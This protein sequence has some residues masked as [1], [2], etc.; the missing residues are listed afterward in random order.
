MFFKFSAYEK[1][2]MDYI[3]DKI[4]VSSIYGKDKKNNINL[5]FDKASL[6]TEYDLMTFVL[7]NLKENKLVITKI[8]N[9]LKEFKEIRG[10]INRLE[11][12]EILSEVEFFEVKK[13]SFQIRSLCALLGKLKNLP[14]S[15]IPKRMIAVETLL[16]PKGDKIPTFFIY[17][18]YSLRLKE[19]RDEITALNNKIEVEKKSLYHMLEKKYE[20]KIRANGEIR[21]AKSNLFY[22]SISQDP[23]FSYQSESYGLTVFSVDLNHAY[24]DLVKRMDELKV[25]E[26]NEEEEIKLELSLKLQEL[27]DVFRI[28]VERIGNF[29]LILGKASFAYGYD[30]KR[31]KIVETDVFVIMG[32]INI[33]VSDRLRKEGLEYLPIDIYLETG[34]TII[35]GSN[36][37]GK[38]V[39]LK[40]IGQIAS[41]IQLGMFVPAESVEYPIRDFIHISVGD[42]QDMSLGLSSFAGEMVMLSEIIKHSDQRGIILVDELSRGTNPQEGYAISRSITDYLNK[43]NA[44]CVFTSHFD[45]IAKGKTH[46]QVKGLKN[47]NFQ[48]MIEGQSV[49][50]NLHHQMDFSLEKVDDEQSVPKEAIPIAEVLGLNKEIIMNAKKYLKEKKKGDD[51]NE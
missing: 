17:D 25:E 22:Q 15:L 32:G 10:T 26:Y 45:G 50:E 9:T 46:Y 16:D 34:A 43:S 41:M 11:K 44:I 37:G 19:I 14:D 35:T 12:N 39:T 49:I 38:T 8:R 24:N 4:N 21:I 36:M 18:E 47:M 42:S 3:V 40:L 48:E 7:Q 23:H 13:F 6:E 29:D 28:N 33:P 27:T 20:M 31:P 30:L 51:N 2:D 5:F 1:L